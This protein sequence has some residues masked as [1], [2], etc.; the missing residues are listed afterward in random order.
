VLAPADT[1]LRLVLLRLVLLRVV[2]RARAF[3]R[4]VLATFSGA[5][6]AD[7][8]ALHLSQAQL[9]EAH[10]ALAEA[11]CRLDLAQAEAAAARQALEAITLQDGLT[12]LANRRQFDR[13][14]NH[15]FRRAMRTGAPLALI[16]L[17]VDRFKGFNHRYGQA[18]GDACLR[19][20][21]GVIPTLVNRP[22]DLVARY[23][24][25]EIAILLPGTDAAG[26]RSVAEAVAQAV[27]DL[28][29]GHSGSEAGIVTVSAGFEVVEPAHKHDVPGELVQRADI[30]LYAAKR[31]GRNTVRWYGEIQPYDTG[32]LAR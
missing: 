15:E 31:E 23:G 24:G 8:A 7:R 14:L 17:D 6:P 4:R 10:A 30:A 25:E 16:L 26:T 28:R 9:A 22:G 27:R 21:A 12:G 11:R 5:V 3:G 2:S 20:I 1:L 19:A 13:A 18:T 32:A 29:I